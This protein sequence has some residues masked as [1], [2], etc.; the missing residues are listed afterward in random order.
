[1]VRSGYSVPID[2]NAIALD[3]ISAEDRVRNL[4]ERLQAF[5]RRER[6]IN[7]GATGFGRRS[8]QAAYIR[9]E[10]AAI[11]R[12]LVVAEGLLR[13]AQQAE[14]TARAVLLSRSRSVVN[15]QSKFGRGGHRGGRGGRGAGR[16]R[17]R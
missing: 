5:R 11:L 9:R 7:V 13:V 2:L 16:V 12:Q 17:A 6:L 10:I 4:S 14:K 3:T 8:D 15:K 1:M